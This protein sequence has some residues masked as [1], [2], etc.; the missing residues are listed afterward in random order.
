MLNLVVYLAIGI[1]AILLLLF[2]FKKVGE[3]ELAASPRLQ[4]EKAVEEYGE[5]AIISLYQNAQTDE[6][7]AEIAAFVTNELAKM[8]SQKEDGYEDGYGEEDDYSD[9][10]TTARLNI[11]DE[12]IQ[13]IFDDLPDLM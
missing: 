1:A 6:E 8:N 13:I 7:R 11:N 10:D 9:E 2:L 5:P 12:D 4:W 3:K